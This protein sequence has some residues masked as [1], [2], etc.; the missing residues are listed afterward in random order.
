MLRKP[1][2]GFTLIEILVALFVFTI[3]ALLMANALR[4]IINLQAGVVNAS[5]KLRTLQI[6]FL[7]IERDLSQA[8]NRATLGL[9]NK[10]QASFSGEKQQLTFVQD[11]YLNH[12]AVANTSSMQRI[13]YRVEDQQLW[14]CVWPRLDAIAKDQCSSQLLLPWVNNLEMRYLDKSKHWQPNWPS[15]SAAE[16]LPLAVKIVLDIQGWGKIERIFLVAENNE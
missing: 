12:N 8:V 3:I 14:R 1:P 10:L 9:D 15:K 2:K 7:R 5:Q 11:G 6:G 13:T 4:Y 16:A